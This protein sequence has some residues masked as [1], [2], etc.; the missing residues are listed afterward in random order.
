MEVS[1]FL[2]RSI[3]NARGAKN[4]AQF[5]S[6]T[7]GNMF[8]GKGLSTTPTRM[9][10]RSISASHFIFIGM[11]RYIRTMPSGLIIAYARK[12]DMLR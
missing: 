3:W 5:S 4:S 11:T 6:A 8:C 10:A 9:Y 7:S 1:N 12:S 2:R